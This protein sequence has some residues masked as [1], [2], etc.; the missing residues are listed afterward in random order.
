[1]KK[2][3]YIISSA[4]VSDETKLECHNIMIKDTYEEAVTTAKCCIAQDFDYSSWSLYYSERQPEI[5][6]DGNTFC[7]YDRLYKQD[8][9]SN[10]D[11]EREVCYRI[12][13][14]LL[15]LEHDF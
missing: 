11:E 5:S 2:K 4:Y 12:D 14:M 7:I 9:N 3:V 1:M 6:A 13:A 15:S 8:R 10:H